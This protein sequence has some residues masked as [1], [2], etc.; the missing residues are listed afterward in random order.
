MISFTD[1]SRGASVA[2]AP[3]V[4]NETAG[5]TRELARSYRSGRGGQVEQ[6]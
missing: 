3:A 6:G 2:L 4:K 5:A 1:P